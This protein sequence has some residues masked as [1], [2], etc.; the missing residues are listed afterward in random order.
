MLLRRPLN[1]V[2]AFTLLFPS[3]LTQPAQGQLQCS[4]MKNR[5][6]QSYLDGLPAP[7]LIPP[8]VRALQL[9][10]CSCQTLLG[11][12][13]AA[14]MAPNT[15]YPI[16]PQ[17]GTWVMQPYGTTDSNGNPLNVLTI[18]VPPQWAYSV[19]KGSTGPNIWA[20]TG[21]RYD[22]VTNR[23]QCET[24]S[25]GDQYDCSSGAFGPP[26]YS[27][28]AEWTFYQPDGSW[29]F[30]YP[31][32]SLVNG[33]NLTMD[34][35][36]LG[37]DA[38]DPSAPTNE[39]WLNW[40]YPLSVFGNDLRANDP[41]SNQNCTDPNGNSF[42]LTRADI[43]KYGNR[44]YDYVIVDANGDPTMPKGNN[45]LACFS[46]CGKQ[47]FNYALND[48]ECINPNNP[49]CYARSVFCADPNVTYGH[50]CVQDS[51][52]TQYQGGVNLYTSCYYNDPANQTKGVCALRAFYQ[53]PS[54]ECPLT[55]QNG[56]HDPGA[57]AHKVACTFT[58]GSSNPLITKGD[59]NIY[60]AQPPAYKCGNLTD[61]SGNPVPCVGDD[62]IHQVFHGGLTWPNDPETY[63]GDAAAYRIIFSPGGTDVP[64]TPAQS[65]VPL[66]Q[67]LP[68][69]YN[70][71]AALVTCRNNIQ[72][73]GSI[74][75]IAMSD[76]LAWSCA[77]DQRG[78]A[79]NG[80]L[81][82]WNPPPPG[83]CS[84]PH[85]DKY[86]TKSACG[87]IDSGTSLSSTVIT[88]ALKDELFVE[89]TIANA[90]NPVE[91]PSSIAGCAPTWTVVKS[92]SINNNEGLVI[93]YSGSSIR[94]SC[95]VVVTLANSNPAAMKVYDV[96]SATGMLDTFGVDSGSYVY[97]SP[98]YPT[99]TTGLITTTHQPDLL[100]G[101][102]LQVNKQFTPITYWENWLTDAD[103]SASTYPNCTSIGC[104]SDD[105][106]DFLPGHGPNSSNA[107]AGHLYLAATGTYQI[108]RSGGN[109]GSFDWGTVA[110]AIKL[111][112]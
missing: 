82:R 57:P 21:C 63:K 60:S 108:N 32:I 100:L 10:N 40:N 13:N 34:I 87:K 99:V 80:V 1:L 3:L 103:P 39:M 83:N 94:T 54:T 92:Q 7:V 2:L 24:G 17:E 30:D 31:D 41:G 86:V 33:A 91:M 84:S 38:L 66:C 36:P 29:F 61:P 27:T 79:S 43:H 88:P 106:T 45:P 56:P 65:Y 8:A 23:A 107:E 109:F 101:S 4:Q 62:L 77:L 71:S 15:P 16:F 59:P 22:P 98:T 72:N 53:T 105:G 42:V 68:S 5:C 47:E 81:C 48:K 112:Q 64:I 90:L 102:L 50:S 12:A 9:V 85:T 14:A 11:A 110:I 104:P 35:E 93:W 97:P 70:Y 111:T 89:V 95:K 96:P 18:Q 25:C 46:N 75:G 51:D 37:G 58:Y 67:S 55:Q 74:F 76:N 6:S 44:I 26:G 69:N 49:N 78:A 52:C 28:I 19:P 20:R 73:E